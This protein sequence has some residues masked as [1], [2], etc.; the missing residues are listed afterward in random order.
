MT[1]I[2]RRT[3]G[4]GASLL[5]S[6]PLWAGNA[7][8]QAPRKGGTLV[9]AS[10]AGPGTLDPHV[11]SSAVD[12]EPIHNL[13]EGL[14]ALDGK[15]A[16]RP[17]LASKAEA[18]ADFKTYSFELRRGVTFHDGQKLTSADVKASFERYQKVSPNAKNLADVETY[19]TPDDH[20]FIIRLKQAN[21][22][23]LDV[24]KT[25]IF[26]LMILPASQRDKAGRAIDVVGTGPYALGEW[27]KD[28]HLLMKRF[29][30]YAQDTSAPGRDGYAGRKTVYLD[31]VRIVFMPEA[32]TRIAGLQTGEVQLAG[33]LPAELR[34]RVE[35]RPDLA[36]RE[37]FPVG[38][39]YIITNSQYGL[40]ANVGIRQ[41]IAA[42]INIEEIDEAV[43]GISKPNGWM[44]FPNTPYYM[45]DVAEAPWY[46]QNNPAKAKE[47]LKAAG[48]KNEK[49]IIETNSNYQYM[50]STLLV[51]AEQLTNIGMNVDVK[52]VD[53][54]T[55][56]THMQTGTGEWNLSTTLFGPD[57]VLG[58]Q[59]W[60]P[61]LYAFP[62]IKGNDALDAAYAD[63]FSQP[64]LE[65][66]RQAWL[67]IQQ[68]VLGKAYMIKVSD[69][70][71]LAGY[72]KR[73]KG[74]SDYPSILQ[75]WDLYLE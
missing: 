2:N 22:V 41:A 46:N 10:P 74:Q 62:N 70:G 20:T 7:A 67:K 8:A 64:E 44:S 11:A 45:G 33:A 13:F 12:L 14:V 39:T 15:N 25:P 50:R 48:Y 36:V 60:R 18:S 32:T 24:L 52:I 28:S 57:H 42:A 37:I 4:I 72:S 47:L 1:A 3:F 40:T 56:A 6:L 31:A 65:K 29:D 5:G 73:L 43:G 49:L 35:G 30:A 75:L 19:E 66:R 59:Q 27:V 9:Y 71:R 53:W 17:M 63:F 16:T 68:E 26:P 58:P 61:L 38:G 51:V 55:N 54:T 34:A 69:A 23:L 21:V